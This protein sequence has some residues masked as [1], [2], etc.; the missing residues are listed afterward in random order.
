MR[1]LNEILN[2]GI[3]NDQI[4]S[5]IDDV[6]V[7]NF[8]KIVKNDNSNYKIDVDNDKK[9]ITLPI[10]GDYLYIYRN[11][12]GE[13]FQGFPSKKWKIVNKSG[14][15]FKTLTISCSIDNLINIPDSIKEISLGGYMADYTQREL[16]N[17]FEG[18]NKAK[19]LQTLTVKCCIQKT[20]LSKLTLKLQRLNIYNADNNI[21]PTVVFNPNQKVSILEIGYSIKELE[22]LPSGIKQITSKLSGEDLIRIMSNVNVGDNDISKIIFKGRNISQQDI[23]SIK[24]N[25]SGQED[26]EEKKRFDKNKAL[27]YT[28]KANDSDP[29]KDA[30][31]RPLKYGDVVYMVNSPLTGTTPP[32]DI[33]VG[34]TGKMIKCLNTQSKPKFIIKMDVD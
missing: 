31:G 8:V 25:A 10:P 30:T 34:T 2:E 18:C 29:T 1:N 12:N 11:K 33:Y 7:N 3:F 9:I 32:F 15:E 6:F 22:N 13:V 14:K 27:I 4:T 16:D 5:D 20:D 24:R 26:T 23:E 28:L 17:I 21:K 19:N